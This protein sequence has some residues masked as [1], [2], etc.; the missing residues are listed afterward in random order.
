MSSEPFVWCLCTWS[1]HF[2][3]LTFVPSFLQYCHLRLNIPLELSVYYIVQVT[4]IHSIVLNLITCRRES[5]SCFYIYSSNILHYRGPVYRESNYVVHFANISHNFITNFV[6]Q[7]YS[8]LPNMDISFL[9][10]LVHFYISVEHINEYWLLCVYYYE[11][12]C[13][14]DIASNKYKVEY[15]QICGA[16]ADWISYQIGGRQL[17]CIYA[18]Y[19]WKITRA[20][21]N[22]SLSTLSV[23]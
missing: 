23:E 11:S 8:S 7:L 16:Q 2:G 13:C 21:R 14:F 10:W 3:V 9:Y 18:S 22:L 15:H 5:S 4:T 20:T 19:L 6:I 1:S 12:S 17:L